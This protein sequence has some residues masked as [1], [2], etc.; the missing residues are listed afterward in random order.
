VTRDLPAR[1]LRLLSLLQTRRA[2]AGAE[3]ADRLGVTAR[4]VRRDI[5]RLRE[6]GYPVDSVPG[7]TGGYR[8]SSGT[9]VP[10]LLLD[11][12]EAVAIA[13]A[14]RTVTSGLTGIAEVALRALAKLE[15]VLPARLH[16]RVTALQH[17]VT[18]L[19]YTGGGPQANP[20][21]LVTVAAAC[22]DHE[23]IT[24][25]YTTRHGITGLRRVEP[26]G[27]VAAGLWY[28]VGYDTD[29][30]DWRLYRLDRMTDPRPTGRR[31][32]PRDLPAADPAAYVA[33]KITTAPTR[34][35]ALA[36]ISAPA[37]TVRTR[38][39]GALPARI[40]PVDE[41]TC[42]LDLSGDWLPR[43]AAILASLDTDYT[44]D[45]DPDIRQHLATAATRMHHAASK[46]TS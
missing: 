29:R 14:L 6:L 5:D 31:V 4:T 15:R 11:D 22:R 37:D 9:D 8:L 41:H 10:P 12:D 33:D 42:T 35:R 23:I 44:L 2:W 26:H 45:A 7:H 34:Y 19:H 24:F 16:G 30:D 39:W 1:L 32:A 28:L 21:V 27:V 20:G 3:L 25:D 13:V 46:R 36:T 40:T 38:T 17:T 18:P 43:I